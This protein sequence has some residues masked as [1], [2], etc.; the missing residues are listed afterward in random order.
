MLGVISEKT[1]KISL[2]VSK[3]LKIL[4]EIL[5]RHEEDVELLEAIVSCLTRLV[6]LLDASCEVSLSALGNGYTVCQ[7][8]LTFHNLCV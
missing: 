8:L 1:R 7:P 6:P 5:Y 4:E 3:T 2:L